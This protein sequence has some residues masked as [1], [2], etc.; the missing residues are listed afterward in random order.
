MQLAGYE[1]QIDA[2]T[3]L[4]ATVVAASVDT[5]EDASK[6]AESL[7]YPV[8][9]GVTRAIV[10]QLESWWEERR[11]IIQPSEFIM[12]A[13]GTIKTSIYS[14]GSVGRIATE[15]A[16]KMLTFYES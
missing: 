8:A 10:D 4:G 3:A 2:L 16:A 12:D 9:E 11:S 7:S 1:A 14:S 5:G 13:D 15:A 6:I